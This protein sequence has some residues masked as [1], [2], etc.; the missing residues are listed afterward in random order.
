VKTPARRHF[1][2]LRARDVFA[3]QANALFDFALGGNPIVIRSNLRRKSR[4][5]R[6]ADWR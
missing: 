1:A 4:E 3:S 5:L 6:A 2:V